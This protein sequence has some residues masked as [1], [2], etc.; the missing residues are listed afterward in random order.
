MQCLKCGANSINAD[1]FVYKIGQKSKPK[2]KILLCESCKDNFESLM[3]PVID[4]IGCLYFE[5]KKYA[6]IKA[7]RRVIPIKTWHGETGYHKD[8]QWF[9]K[10]WDIDRNAVRDFAMNDILKFIKIETVKEKNDLYAKM[11]W[12]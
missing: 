8:Y 6:G 3:I 2:H 12:E 4:F 10:A 7:I 11:G 5:Y 9:L 1:M